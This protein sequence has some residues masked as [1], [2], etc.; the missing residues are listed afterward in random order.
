M[1]T[2]QLSPG[3]ITREVDLTVGRADN[4]LANVGAIAGPFPLGPVDEAIDITTEQELINTFGKPLSTDT[5]YEYW[6]S[7][8]SYLSYGGVLKVARVNGGTLNSANAG[9]GAAS[10]SSLNIRNFDDY[11]SNHSDETVNYTYAAKSPGSYSNNLKVAFIDDLADQTLGITTTN[12]GNFGAK[13]GFGVTTALSGV[14]VGVGT[15][16]T[17]GGHLKGIITGV[18]TDSSGGSSEIDVKITARVS[19]AGIETAITY[20]ESNSL[21]QFDASDTIFFMNNSG[22][23]TGPTR[24]DADGGFSVGSAVDWYNQ[25]QLNLINTSIYWKQIAPKPVTNQYSA[26]RSSKNDAM[27]IVIVD[28]TGTVS[29][30]QG[31]I[32]EKHISISKANDAVSSVNSPQKTFYKNYLA[33]FSEYIY[34]G[35]NPSSLTDSYHGTE[36]RATGFSTDFTPVT[37]AAGLWGLDTQGVTFNAIGNVTYPL[38]GGVD[39]SAAGGMK[40]TLGDLVS[41][42]E[43]FANKD[44]TS[45]NFLIQGPGLTEEVESQAKANKLIAIAEERKDCVAVISPHRANVVNV[46]STATQTNN[47][48]GFFAPI[49]SSSYAVFDSGYKYTYDRF[50]NLFRFIP[51]NADVAG[52]MVRTDIEQFPWYSP[53]GQARG[54]LNNAIKLAY[55]PNKA[56]RDS[57]YEARVNPIVNQPGSG[58]LLF[59]DKTGLSFASA[60]DR[61]NVRRLFLTVEKSLEGVANAQLLEFNDEITRANFINVV[62][63]FLRDVQAKRGLFDFRVI[64]DETNNTPDVIDNNEF[65]ADIF[66]KPTKSINYVTL[67]FVAT[68][69]GVSFEEVTGRV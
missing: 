49:T 31:T 32:L 23:T 17:I 21:Y 12:A 54:T 7:A 13:I 68:R 8:A 51:T 35:R 10:S 38:V 66:L 20:A 48:V 69:T 59:G 39:Y 56:Q 1:A 29:G 3:V 58:V 26:D 2:P 52:L 43:L 18:R 16:A 36:P 55:N 65:R 41:A 15:T 63:P 34:A 64:C 47:I 25:Q 14:S 11:N 53:A 19:S 40:A 50:N 6:M 5:Q 4:V 22:V 67:S 9:V 46:T 37:T 61:I 33:N 28:D 30:I 62:E 60:F 57:L 42:Y 27:H 44:E 45:V 24:T